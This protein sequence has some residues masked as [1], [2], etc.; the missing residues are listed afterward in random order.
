MSIRKLSLMVV[1]ALVGL[2]VRKMAAAWNH[3]RV[4][5]K[6]TNEPDQF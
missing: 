4:N 3:H 5:R 2:Y 1:M 6:C